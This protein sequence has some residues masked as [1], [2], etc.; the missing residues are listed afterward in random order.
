MYNDVSVEFMT[1][2][3]CKFDVNNEICQLSFK[4][5][6][7]SAIRKDIALNS[8]RSSAHI[9]TGHLISSTQDTLVNQANIWS[10][11]LSRFQNFMTTVDGVAGVLTI[12]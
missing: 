12:H 4:I 11:F 8:S 5:E 7:R 1:A 3:F 9:S 10:S 2:G 6:L